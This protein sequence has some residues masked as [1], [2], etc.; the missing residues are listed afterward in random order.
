VTSSLHDAECAK[1][2]GGNNLQPLDVEDLLLAKDGVFSGMQAYKNSKLANMLFTYE[3]A[4]QVE[5]SGVKVNAVCPGFIP[6]T[7]LMRS[8]SGPTKFY[9]R[10]VL[11]GMLR[12]RKITRTVQQA[13]NS[14]CAIA[15]DEK[16]K[17]ANGKYFRDGVESKS[18]EESLDEATQKKVWELSARYTHLAGFEPLDA[19]PPPVEEVKVEPKKEEAANNGEAA[20]ERK[21]G[22]DEPKT[23]TA[24]NGDKPVTANEEHKVE[25]KAVTKEAEENNEAKDA[26]KEQA[27]EEKKVP[28]EKKDVKQEHVAAEKKETETEHVVEDK[29]DVEKEHVA[30]DKK[31]EPMVNGTNGT[32]DHA[33]KE[34]KLAVVEKKDVTA[35]D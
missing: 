27:P 15:L 34:V 2:R 8:V 7:E 20:K 18:S 17:D 25:E 9:C 32:E 21:E 10:Y 23:E 11:H 16:F 29:K 26:K 31:A 28:E 4:R 30:E 3:L 19:P 12:F 22:D 14:I 35:A 5:G 33:D 1:K 13:A 6:T 24:E